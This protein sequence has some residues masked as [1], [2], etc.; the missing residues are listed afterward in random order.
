[1]TLEKNTRKDLLL[2]HLTVFIW[3]FTGVLGKLISIDAVRMV[4]YRVFIAIISLAIYFIF[5]KKNI[6]V[7]KKNA[8][9]FFFTGGIVAIHWVFFFHAIKISTVS[10]GLVC[11]SSLT[12]FTSVLEPLIKRKPF[13]K[14]DIFVGLLIILGI[15]LIFKFETKYTL[16][17]IFGLSTALAASLFSIINSNFVQNTKA[18]IISFYELVGAFFWLTLYRLF[19]NTLLNESLNLS[20]ADWSYLFILG[21]ICTALAYVVGVSVMKN[22]SA[23]T[24]ALV[25]NLEPIYGILIALVF[26]NTHEKMSIGFYIGTAIILG[27]VF[28]FPLYKKRKKIPLN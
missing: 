12:L 20:L 9:N 19:D 26:L 11:L 22:L 14:V 6:K 8:F 28:L 7:S 27:S 25:T 24:V 16:G 23:F 2:L 18:E 13:Y 3:G 21:T 5:S 15:Y 17:I 4:W 10:V 1:M